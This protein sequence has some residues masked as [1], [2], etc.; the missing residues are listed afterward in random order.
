MS[1]DILIEMMD[2]SYTE[3]HDMLCGVSFLPHTTTTLMKFSGG[4]VLLFLCRNG[5]IDRSLSYNSI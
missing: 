5:A 4:G 1:C 2:K 3:R